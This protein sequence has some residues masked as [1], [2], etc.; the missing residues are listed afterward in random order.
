MITVWAGAIV[1]ILCNSSAVNSN[2]STAAHFCC[3]WERTTL[4]IGNKKRV[5]ERSR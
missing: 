3:L 1:F 2:K 5:K 4:D